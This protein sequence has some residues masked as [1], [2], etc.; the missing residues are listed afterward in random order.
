MRFT[1]L[2]HHKKNVLVRGIQFVLAITPAWRSGPENLPLRLKGW[3]A[4]HC[5]AHRNFVEIGARSTRDA[6]M[7]IRS[8]CRSPT[9][10]LESLA[11]STLRSPGHASPPASAG[12][13]LLGIGADPNELNE[14]SRTPLHM[15]AHKDALEMGWLLLVPAQA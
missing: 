4:L 1:K 7:L 15:A 6:K 2:V 13:L 12:E 5:A 10:D 8:R 11:L 14:F 9:P 3:T